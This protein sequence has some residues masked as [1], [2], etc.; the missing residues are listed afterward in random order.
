MDV[1][2]LF[3]HFAQ[4]AKTTKSRYYQLTGYSFNLLLLIRLYLLKCVF[5]KNYFPFN[6]SFHIFS[7]QG[8]L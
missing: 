4:R 2:Y 6:F 5:K 3:H 8:I 7:G 1:P